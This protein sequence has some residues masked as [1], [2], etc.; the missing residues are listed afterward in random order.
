[1]TDESFWMNVLAVF[2]ISCLIGHEWLFTAQFLEATLLTNAQSTVSVSVT[3]DEEAL[4]KA[5]N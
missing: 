5:Y 3:A 1:M 4:R 2:C